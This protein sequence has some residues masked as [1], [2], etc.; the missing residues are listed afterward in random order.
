[1]ITKE[2]ESWNNHWISTY[3]NTMNDVANATERNQKVAYAITLYR[4]SLELEQLWHEEALQVEDL[5]RKLGRSDYEVKSILK[6]QQMLGSA[7][8]E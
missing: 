1:M 3:F 2:I 4:I 7:L 8:H 5:L 6:E